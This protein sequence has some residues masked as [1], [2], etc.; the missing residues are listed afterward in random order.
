MFH[1][2]KTL[3]QYETHVRTLKISNWL[4]YKETPKSMERGRQPF[5][6]YNIITRMS[7]VIADARRTQSQLVTDYY[8]H[9]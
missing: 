6:T 7:T 4:D 1:F 9:S 3:S 2:K 8:L 5:N